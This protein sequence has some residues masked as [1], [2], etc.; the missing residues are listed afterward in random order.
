ML[1]DPSV[2]DCNMITDG[3]SGA[4]A[5]YRT[6]GCA[7]EEG[8]VVGRCVV[9]ALVEFPNCQA[10][11]SGRCLQV[12]AGVAGTNE[13]FA[14]ANNCFSNAFSTC[15][16]TFDSSACGKLSLELGEFVACAKDTCSGMMAIVVCDAHTLPRHKVRR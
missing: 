14:V 16:A 6:N 10:F 2:I 4:I 13:T 11:T 7:A 12:A 8:N 1:A 15:V 5:C 3:Y 9:A